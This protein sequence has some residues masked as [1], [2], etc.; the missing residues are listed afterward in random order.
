MAG[1]NRL[2]IDWMPRY[3]PNGGRNTMNVLLQQPEKVD[4]PAEAQGYADVISR[5]ANEGQPVIVRRE[6]ND[7]AAI[8]PLAYLEELLDNLAMQ[9]AQR[10]AK[11]IDWEKVR[12]TCRPPQE[13]FDRDEPKPF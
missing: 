8:V 2:V 9:E 1:V 4:E 11:S 5:V 13:W 10:I 12:A 3:H 6:G 7:V